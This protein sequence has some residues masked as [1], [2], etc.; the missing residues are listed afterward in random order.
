[1]YRYQ[2]KYAAGVLFFAI[3]NNKIYTLLGEDQYGTYSD[4]GGRCESYDFNEAETAAREC[5]EETCGV[6][7]SYVNLK[8][9]CQESVTVKS[10]TFYKK[11]YYMFLTFISYDESLP[12]Q[13]QRGKYIIDSLNDLA[14]FKEKQR[15]KWILWED[16]VKGNVTLRNM[17]KAT[18]QRNSKSIEDALKIALFNKNT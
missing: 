10:E 17:F 1:M 11:P 6:V 14:S 7:D 3:K 18:L 9:K 12:I 8:K 2:F 16:V 13:F 4:F 15:I 5:Y